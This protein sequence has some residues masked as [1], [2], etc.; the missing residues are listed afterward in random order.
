E[1]SSRIG[2]ITMAGVV[3]EFTVPTAGSDPGDIVAGPDGAL[4]FTEVNGN[5]IGRNT[6]AGVITEF[7]VPTAGSGPSGIAAGPDGAIWF[8]E[9]SG[10]IGRISL[11]GPLSL[12]API[13]RGPP[14]G[15]VR[16][17]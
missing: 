6:T 3:T 1:V 9:P 17:R 14:R 4:W 5:K 2:R 8:T 16:S 7:P 11:E 12:R 13:T 15:P 10:K